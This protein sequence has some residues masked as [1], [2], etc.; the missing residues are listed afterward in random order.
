[1]RKGTLKSRCEDQGESPYCQEH[2]CSIDNLR[3]PSER[4]QLYDETRGGR[5]GRPQRCNK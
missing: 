4:I 2:R 5:L 3:L 1:M